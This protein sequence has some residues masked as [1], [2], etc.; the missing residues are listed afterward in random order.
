MATITTPTTQPAWRPDVYAFSPTDAV[1][2]ALIVNLT[3]VGADVDGDAPSVHVGYITDDTAV[4]KAEGA[5]L[6]EAAPA[7]NEAVIHTAKL[8]Q[9]VRLSREQFYQEQTPDQLALSVNRAIVRAAD[10]AFLSQAAPTGGA[11]APMPGVLN[12]TGVVAAA[13]PVSASLDPI[14][15]LIGTLEHNLSIPT[16][17]VVDPLGWA[18]IRKLK[19]ATGW[20]ASLV[21]A[22]VEDAQQLLFSLPVYVNPGMTTYSG[23]VIDQSAIVS[24]L[25]PVMIATSEHTYFASDG[26]ALRALWRFGHV[27]VRPN[28]IGKFTI[29]APGS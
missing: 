26:V 8:T 9:L 14:A 29:T 4:F 27:V 19:V 23:L 13:A 2:D 7:L 12:V 25:G 21:G 11:V 17:I 10:V 15:D 20:N 28:R 18:Q 6:D 24:A 1:P 5:P 16:A 22:G 3:T